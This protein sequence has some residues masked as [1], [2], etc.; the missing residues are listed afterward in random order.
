MP[1]LVQ[2]SSDERGV[3]D[4]GTPHIIAP[5]LTRNM[6]ESPA[7]SS[8]GDWGDSRTGEA[9]SLE[10]TTYPTTLL[11]DGHPAWQARC[12]SVNGLSTFYLLFHFTPGDAADGRINTADSV[13]I[14][15]HNFNLIQAG[16]ALAI[17]VQ[18]SPGDLDDFSD[19]VTIATIP[20]SATDGIHIKLPALNFQ[21]G[22]DDWHY[23]D[24]LQYARLRFRCTSGSFNSIAP[25]AG[26][27]IFGRKSLFASWPI[28]PFTP[29]AAK[30]DVRGGR[31]DGGVLERYT[32]YQGLYESSII[33][34]LPQNPLTRPTMNDHEAWNVFVDDIAQGSQPFCLVDRPNGDSALG[35]PRMMFG[36]CDPELLD[37]LQGPEH[38]LGELFFR[39]DAPFRR[40]IEAKVDYP[41]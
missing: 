35:I 22:T 6:A 23:L 34:P 39:E 28:L 18:Y 20:V 4:A 31:T 32:F 26:Q 3:L 37:P 12:A 25:K 13:V 30:S 24:D 16:G 5:T 14:C 1:N 19:A 38:A 11:S 7:W 36:Y 29:N 10:N 40:Y 17:D 21:T 2:L 27:V 8:S 15:N 33:W 41:R 9:S